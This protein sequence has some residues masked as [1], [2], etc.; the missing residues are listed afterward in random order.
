MEQEQELLNILS[1]LDKNINS[2]VKILIDLLIDEN[3]EN[4]NLYNFYLKIND[5]LSKRTIIKD[6]I[7]HLRLE[8]Y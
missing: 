2:E 8:K 7:I 5:L 1:E 4:I 3:I 6:K